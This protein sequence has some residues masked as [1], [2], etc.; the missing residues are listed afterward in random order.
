MLRPEQGEFNFSPSINPPSLL[1]LMAYRIF[2]LALESA[3]MVIIFS[4]DPHPAPDR[5]EGAAFL[6]AIFS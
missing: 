4:L 3:P 5:R 6:R 2:Q 1:F